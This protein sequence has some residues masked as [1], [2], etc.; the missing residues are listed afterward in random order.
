M[1]F[2]KHIEWLSQF[3]KKECE[4]ALRDEDYINSELNHKLSAIS[5]LTK[6]GFSPNQDKIP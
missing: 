1:E 4:R 3:F 6:L 5:V 2:E